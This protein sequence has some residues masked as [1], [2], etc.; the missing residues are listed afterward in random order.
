LALAYTFGNPVMTWY[1]VICITTL[2]I[3]QRILLS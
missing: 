3:R 2:F 1:L